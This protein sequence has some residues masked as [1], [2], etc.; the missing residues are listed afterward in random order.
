MYDGLR[1]HSKPSI[2]L[3]LARF[4]I[5]PLV[6][7]DETVRMLSEDPRPCL[8]GRVDT[9]D[10]A[11]P[12]ELSR[13][14]ASD[15]L[16]RLCRSPMFGQPPLYPRR[17]DALMQ[18]DILLTIL[19]SALDGLLGKTEARGIDLLNALSDESS[20]ALPTFDW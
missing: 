5:L 6:D 14:W 19:G 9:T 2:Y 11:G 1:G 18:E 20:E 3:Y 8:R 17:L 7:A 16:R 15:V 12:Q 13:T 4:R 10:L